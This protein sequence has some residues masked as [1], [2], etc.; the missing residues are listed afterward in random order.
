MIFTEVHLLVGKLVLIVAI[1]LL[2]GSHVNW[3]HMLN[4]QSGA[5]Q[6]TQYE[7]P[8]ATCNPLEMPFVISHGEGSRTPHNHHD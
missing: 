6:P 1:H 5:A 8:Q 7:D 3:H 4:P 2:G